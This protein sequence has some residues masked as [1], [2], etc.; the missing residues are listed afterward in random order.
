MIFKRY[1]LFYVPDFR[2]LIVDRYATETIPPSAP[3]KYDRIAVMKI[4]AKMRRSVDLSQRVLD[5][6]RLYN[7]PLLLLVLLL[8]LHCRSMQISY[9]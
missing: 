5:R 6:I 2:F 3:R 1:K 8:I 7:I 4:K 9:R